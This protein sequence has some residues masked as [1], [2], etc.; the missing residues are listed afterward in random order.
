M[1][2]RRAPAGPAAEPDLPSSLV[3]HSSS[4]WGAG[5]SQV[6]RQLLTSGVRCFAANGF[7]ATTT[8]DVTSAVG[9][10]PGALYVHFP[11]KEDLLFE[12]VSTAHRHSFEAVR[13]VPQAEDASTHLRELVARFVEWHARHHV[14]GRVSQYELGALTSEHHHE[15]LALRRQSSEVFRKAV[16]RGIRSQEFAN[17]DVRRVTRAIVSLGVD[18]VR[19]YRLDGPDSPE[20]MGRFYGDLALAMI[21]QSAAGRSTT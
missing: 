16:D 6:A 12:I 10:S 14:A 11:S 2:A 1:A 7:H 4:L 17:L 21:T 9:L 13:A 20:E 18:L 15:I 8:R 5:H 3:D 19:W